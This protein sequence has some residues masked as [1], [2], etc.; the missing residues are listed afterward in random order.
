MA[1]SFYPY[2][3]PMFCRGG[4]TGQGSSKKLIRKLKSEVD[5]KILDKLLAKVK[6]LAIGSMVTKTEEDPEV[7]GIGDHVLLL[8]L[9]I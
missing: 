7:K 2:V 4:S 8:Y 5:V 3:N 1:L 9:H 6:S